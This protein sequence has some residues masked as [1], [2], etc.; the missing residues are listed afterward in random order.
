MEQGERVKLIRKSKG[1]TL[2]KFGEK[3]GMKKNSLSQIE[4]GKNS[5]TDQTALSI[6][7]EYN[8]EYLWL[9]T[10]EGEM[11]CNPDTD[12]KTKIDYIMSGTTSF[13]KDTFLR[14]SRLDDK[15][16]EDLERIMNKLLAK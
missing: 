16:W 8:V 10:G 9:T 15:D 1:M 5:L 13:A 4:N 2:E 14:F 11:F 7:R 12:A 3:I 6:C